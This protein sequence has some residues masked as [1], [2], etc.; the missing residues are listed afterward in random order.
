MSYESVKYERP[1]RVSSKSVVSVA[2]VSNKNVL[3]ILQE[4]CAILSREISKGILAERH[5]GLFRCKIGKQKRAQDTLQGLRVYQWVPALAPPLS[6]FGH[7]LE[8]PP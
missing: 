4:C 8:V 5:L 3:Q 1:R 6:G 2:K 7:S